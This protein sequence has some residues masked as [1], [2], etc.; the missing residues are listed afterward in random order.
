MALNSTPR[1][2]VSGEVVTAAE[3]NAEI[4]D[5]FNGVQAAWTAYT[6]TLTGITL[7]NGTLNCAFTRYGK[8]IKVR[9]N[10]N[11][12]ST[13]TYSATTFAFTLPVTPSTAYTTTGGAAAGAAYIV[14]TAATRCSGTAYITGAGALS[15]LCGTPANSVVTNLVPGTWTTTSSLTFQIEYEAA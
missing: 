4:R 9:G 5:A 2:W 13:T 15:F 12:G 3:M 8:T 11:A 14:A 7:G 10:F 1:T 6:P